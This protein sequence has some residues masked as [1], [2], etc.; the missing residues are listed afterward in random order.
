MS[1]CR[2]T[3]R[4]EVGMARRESIARGA[5]AI[6]VCADRPNERANIGNGISMS[7]AYGYAVI[8]LTL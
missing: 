3:R 5:G 8:G 6:P 2:S 1:E 4:A 7:M